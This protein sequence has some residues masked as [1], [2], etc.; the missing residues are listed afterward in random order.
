MKDVPD[1]ENI[2]AKRFEKRSTR[3]FDSLFSTR[4]SLPVRWYGAG[5]KH[6]GTA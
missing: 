6:G 3:N 1:H 4:P 5:Y 2:L